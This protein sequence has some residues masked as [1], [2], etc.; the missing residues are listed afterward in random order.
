MEAFGALLA[1]L[2]VANMTTG[3]LLALR[4]VYGKRLL[5]YSSVAQVGYILLGLGLG[6]ATRRPEPLVAALYLLV[7]H[8]GMKGLAFLAK[9]ACHHYCQATLVRD[10]DGMYRRLP[11]AATLLVFAL[12]GL[13]G[14]PPLAGFVAKWQLLVGALGSA[15]PWII[16]ALVALVLNTLLSLGYYLPLIGRILRPG[17]APPEMQ[18]MAMSHWMLVP[19]VAVGAAVVLVSLVPRPVLQLAHEAALYLLA[20]GG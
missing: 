15:T 1:V 10:L 18:P 13:A 17:G 16:A 11:G 9:G 8:A 2:A 6:L 19:G 12:A 20:I 4:Q 14:I 3:N 7:A 5:A